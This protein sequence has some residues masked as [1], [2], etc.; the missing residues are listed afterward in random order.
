MK[1]FALGSILLLVFCSVLFFIPRIY[2]VKAMMIT[3][4]TFYIRANGDV[5]PQPAPISKVDNITYKFSTS[6]TYT[7][8]NSAIVVEKDNVVIDGTG[9][10]L[11]G[12]G[13]GIGIDL[14]QRRNVT[15]KNLNIRLFDSG[16][17]ISDNINL[18]SSAGS[19]GCNKI[20]SCFLSDNNISIQFYC[21]VNL[22]SLSGYDTATFG[23]NYIYSNN[24]SQNNV[25]ILFG[26]NIN[27][28][29]LSDSAS[30]TFGSN[31]IYGNSIIGNSF[32]I[33]TDSNINIL[34]INASSLLVFGHNLIFNNNLMNNTEVSVEALNINVL[35]GFG[36][37]LSGVNFWDNGYP[38]GGNYWSD[39]NGTDSGGD[40]IGDTQYLI[41]ANN[42]DN[43]PLMGMF[44]SFNTSY[45]YAVDFVSNSSISHFDFSMIN[46]L[47]ASLRFNV[48]GKSETEGF[49]RI[50]IPKILI[51]GSYVVTF[52]GEVITNITCPQVRELPCSNEAYEYLY[53]NYT[54]SEH[55]IEISGTTIIPE[56]PPLIILP[57]SV[58]TTL[59]ATIVHRRKQTA[60]PNL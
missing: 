33:K 30:A 28:L 13:S 47:Q 35:N 50:C 31:K 59:L 26:Y 20:Y 5:E 32:A 7:G 4:V 2:D 29:T 11:Q 37:V 21:N 17:Y 34:T 23:D 46:S 51:N 40:G 60:T 10:M 53:I 9:N 44:S 24:I 8:N 56:F 48:T 16:I 1:R 15:V 42:I 14:T 19:H 54:H 27:S 25:G 41:D 49:V 58:I 18:A 45:G 52:D 3:S 55:T 57:L 43:Y 22:L 39:Y 6:W 12:V 36:T 38:S